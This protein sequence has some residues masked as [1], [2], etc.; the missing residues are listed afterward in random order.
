MA[1]CLRRGSAV[2]RLLGL[3]VRIPPG[4]LM[5]APVIVVLCQVSVTGRPLVRR[6]PAE[7]VCLSLRVISCNI[8][9][10]HLQRAE[11]VQTKEGRKN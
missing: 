7:L 10:V 8:N 3:R 2:A 6:C 5:S 9:P 11:I 4:E 1:A